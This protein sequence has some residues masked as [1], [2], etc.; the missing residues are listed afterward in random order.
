LAPLPF[1]R[2]DVPASGIEAWIAPLDCGP[3]E[4]EGYCQLLS[5][6]ERVRADRF[7]FPHDR[8]R[9]AV[10]HGCLRMLLGRHL[11]MDPAVMEFDHTEYGKPFLARAPD[12]HFNLS[13]SGERA[14]FALS[15]DH[16]VG[17]DIEFLHK[18]VDAL[19]LARRYFAPNECASLEAMPAER[20][21]RAFFA[22]WT[23]KEAVL[24]A[25]GA[26]LTVPLDQFEVSVDPEAPP[27][28]L[29]SA[30]LPDGHWALCSVDVGPDYYASIASAQFS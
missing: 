9:F 5:Q 16:L 26:G 3:D 27:R 13:H 29:A 8:R 11:G 7:Q 1:H 23:R 19:A 22:C 30:G 25:M 6:A 10:S 28:L 24:K 2:L 12:F 17:V 21:Q 14:L 15:A 4:V 18:E 20:R